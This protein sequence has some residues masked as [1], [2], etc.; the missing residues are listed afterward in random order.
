MGQNWRAANFEREMNDPE[1][2]LSFYKKVIAYRKNN[3]LIRDGAFRL[4]WPEHEKLFAYERI[5]GSQKLLVLCNF[6]AETV[7]LPEDLHYAKESIQLSNLPFIGTPNVMR[8]Y[9][10]IA[11]SALA[12]E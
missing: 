5:L 7:V 10:A 9:E 12:T 11:I 3:P 6:R 4:L 1:S 8:P 2:V